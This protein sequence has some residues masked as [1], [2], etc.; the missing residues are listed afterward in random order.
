MAD[1]YTRKAPF[2]QVKRDLNAV[3]FHMQRYENGSIDTL[4]KQCFQHWQQLKTNDS[5]KALLNGME[6][7]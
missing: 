6:G 3:K 1:L 5:Y 7:T 4:A 2:D